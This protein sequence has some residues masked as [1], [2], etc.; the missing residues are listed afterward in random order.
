VQVAAA[1][2]ALETLL[3]AVVVMSACK[4]VVLEAFQCAVASAAVCALHLP[5]VLPARVAT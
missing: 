1:L 3:M 5:R 4:P 2:L